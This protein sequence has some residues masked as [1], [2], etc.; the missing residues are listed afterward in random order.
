MV[1]KA[2]TAQAR[3]P[4]LVQL[5]LITMQGFHFPLVYHTSLNM[6]AFVFWKFSVFK[7]TDMTIF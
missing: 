4:A 2:P 7:A 6:I 5:Q 1:A 3:D